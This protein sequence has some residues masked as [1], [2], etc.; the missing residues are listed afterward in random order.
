MYLPTYVNLLKRYIF[1]LSL[2]IRY[3][4]IKRTQNQQSANVFCQ[5][6]NNSTTGQQWLK[7]LVS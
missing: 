5:E 6:I 7:K 2:V 1:H 3:F 4:T